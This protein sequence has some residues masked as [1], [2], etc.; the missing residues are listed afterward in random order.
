MGAATA[1]SLYLIPFKMLDK[2]CAMLSYFSRV[3]LCVTLW[4]VIRQAHLS[5]HDIFQARI[6]EWV[7]ITSS[8]GSY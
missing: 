2:C 8:R 3:Q 5:V 4:A 7:A 1:K 6:L